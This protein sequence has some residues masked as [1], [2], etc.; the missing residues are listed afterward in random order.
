[1]IVTQ[2]PVTNNFLIKGCLEPTQKQVLVTRGFRLRFI[3]FVFTSK[4]NDSASRDGVPG[5]FEPEVPSGCGM[6]PQRSLC[7]G[8]CT[9]NNMPHR[10]CWRFF[11][12]SVFYN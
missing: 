4:A 3:W 5:I 2:V 10:W 1:M 7:C 11:L 6:M 8:R 12:G 9:M